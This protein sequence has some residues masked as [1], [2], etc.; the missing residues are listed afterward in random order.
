MFYILVLCWHET[1]LLLTAPC[2]FPKV[3]WTLLLLLLEF[4]LASVNGLLGKE[5]PQPWPLIW[6]CGPMCLQETNIEDCWTLPSQGKT[7]F[8]PPCFCCGLSSTLGLSQNWLY[9]RC[10]ETLGDCTGSLLFL[11]SRHLLE[12][13]HPHFL[14]TLVLLFSF[15]GLDEVVD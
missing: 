13:A 10:C 3:C 15:S 12:V 6:T 5:L 7:A 14:S 1:L 11:S 4:I 8:L 2:T 9:Q